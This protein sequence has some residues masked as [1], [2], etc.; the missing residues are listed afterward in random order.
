MVI[1]EEI[2]IY[3][4]TDKK[5]DSLEV[6]KSSNNNKPLEMLMT[7]LCK[8]PEIDFE[9]VDLQAKLCSQAIQSIEETLDDEADI[10]KVIRQWKKLIAE[11][12]YKQMMIM[13]DHFEII[14]TNFHKPKVYPFV[15]IEDWNFTMVSNGYREYT[16]ESMQPSQI[17]KFIFRGF[18]K[19]AHPEY[20]FANRTEQTFAFILENDPIVLKW[21]R[22][23]LY[24]FRIYWN[25]KGQTYQPDFIAETGSFI[26]MIETKAANE[27]D[28]E[29]VKAKANAAIIYCNYANDFIKE[30]GG[31][32]WKYVIIPHDAVAKNS[33]FEGV[34]SPNI[35]K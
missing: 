13:P 14:Q 16:D 32:Q 35:Y 22:P 4:I 26:Y 3:G 17:Q 8:F 12:I 2:L 19:T 21:L 34:V 33:S 31:K 27:I 10:R 15:K 11:K 23:S 29:E 25:H 9:T 18:K 6:T 1:K 5:V 20:K 7:E 30:H 24:Q 28:S